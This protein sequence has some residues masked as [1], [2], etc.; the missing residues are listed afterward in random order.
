M[1]DAAVTKSACHLARGYLILMR[2]WRRFLAAMA[3]AFGTVLA[4]AWAGASPKK[5]ESAIPAQPAVTIVDQPLSRELLAALPAD[6]GISIGAESCFSASGK[7]LSDAACK[8]LK[9]RLGA[10][11]NPRNVHLFGKIDA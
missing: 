1:L 3:L 9:Y 10:V 4:A 5:L 2:I 6:E 7:M 11:D 8:G